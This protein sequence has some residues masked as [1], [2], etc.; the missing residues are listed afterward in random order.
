MKKLS[1]IFILF[2]TLSFSLVAQIKPDT[3]I[4]NGVYKSYFSYKLKEPLY[5]SYILYKG[6]GDCDRK[7]FHFKN[8][9]KINTAKQSDYDHSG[10]DEGHLANAEDFANNCIKDES[11][12]R[13]YNCLPQT[14]NLNRGV[15]KKW[16]T[17]IRTESQTDSLLI[18][19]GGIFTSSKTIGD[20]VAVP[21][22]CFKIVQSM[23]TKRILWG[24]LFTNK[25]KDS[26]MEFKTIE[27]LEKFSQYQLKD[28][29][30]K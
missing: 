7:S 16:E 26:T 29:L 20:K 6:G 15:W 23:K 17:G 27:D 10:F 25:E 4:N 3:L 13:F 18:I 30:S 11:T 2:F 9:T 19:C 22:Y 14:P 24:L 21:D 5:V 8:D 12:F 28:S 1:T